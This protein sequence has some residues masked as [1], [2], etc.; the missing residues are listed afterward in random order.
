MKNIIIVIALMIFFSCNKDSDAPTQPQQIASSSI[1][2]KVNGTETTMDN[3]NLAAGEGVLFSKQLKGTVLSQSR[4][5]LNGQKGANNIILTTIVT[6]SL[7][8]INYHYDSLYNAQNSGIFKF[9]LETDGIVSSLYF[10]GDYL[11]VNI[12]SYKNSSV[13]GTFTAKVSPATGNPSD[14][15]H[16]G[17]VLV[18]EGVFNNIPVTY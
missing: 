4:Y 11:D 17:S 16:R 10:T 8:E 13:T 9:V 3:A 15:I 5:L 6:D 12:T 14:Y 1:S 18:T 2:Y 7:H